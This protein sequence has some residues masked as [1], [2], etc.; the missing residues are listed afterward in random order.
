MAERSG[1]YRLL[2]PTTLALLLVLTTGAALRL[3]A[4]PGRYEM[5]DVDEWDYLQGGLLVLEGL[6]PSYHYSP[7]GPEV[8]LGW[9]YA[10]GLSARYFA[11][12]T[13]EERQVPAQVRLYTAVNHALFD[14]YHD[15]SSLRRVYVALAM[16]LSL[17]AVAAG[18]GLGRRWGGLAGAVLLGGLTACV[19]LLVLYAATSHPYSAAWSFA[20][21][22]MYF[23][24]SGRRHAAIG[25]GVFFG[26]AIASRIEMLTM[27]P[28]LIAGLWPAKQSRRQ[29][30]R[31]GAR[32]LLSASLTALLVAPWL[33]T[34]LIGNLR[35]IA[36]IRFGPAPNGPISARQTLMDFGWN[37][38]LAVVTVLTIGSLLASLRPQTPSREGPQLEDA[39]GAAWPGAASHRRWRWL[40]VGFAVLLL[41]QLL[42]PTGYGMRHQGAAITTLLLASPLAV[43]P[44]MRIGRGVG[45]LVVAACVLLP[46]GQTVRRIA[47]IHRGYAPDQATGWVESH[48]PAGTVVYVKPSFHDPLPTPAA[49]NAMWDEVMARDAAVRKFNSGLSRFG[50]E[51]AEFPRALSEQHVVV[52]RSRVRGWYILGSRG[53]WAGPRF[54]IRRYANSPVFTSLDP[55][56]AFQKTGGVLIWRGAPLPRDATDPPAMSW[57]APDGSGTFVYVS[58]DVR[59]K[60][61]DR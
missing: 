23:A 15:M 57:V 32:C 36:T 46:L 9:A 16:L 29:F 34:H 58:P 3:W 47:L 22:A 54:D 45:W 13:A 28:L 35:A 6:P 11:F 37:E 39:S 25:A 14:T 40:V 30:V 12:P 55:L 10:G 5:R 52:E 51:A 8:W 19:P 33:L 7:E 27:L 18:F 31:D 2:G 44:L 26:L 1:R 53:M 41:I 21:I 24:A 38:G 59:S 61:S 43:P 42:R 50:L 20:V 60:I 56:P 49:A 17:V 4:F 48:V